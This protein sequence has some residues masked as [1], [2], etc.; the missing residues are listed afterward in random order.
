ML[1]AAMAGDEAEQMGSRLFTGDHL[2]PTILA[3]Q[4]LMLEQKIRDLLQRVSKQSNQIL[5]AAQVIPD[6]P[7]AVLDAA[8]EAETGIAKG[9][10]TPNLL[11][12]LVAMPPELAIEFEDGDEMEA[13]DLEAEEDSPLGNFRL[14][15]NNR[16]DPDDGNDNTVDDENDED[17]DVDDIDGNADED[18][19]EGMMTHL[20]AINLRLS[21][22]EF[23]DVQASLW[24]S[25]LRTA[26]GRLRK[27]GKQY[28][29][30]QRELAIAEAE[31]AWRAVWYDDSR[32]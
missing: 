4:H 20:A 2:T 16:Q 27:L 13:E 7:E 21:D 5:K 25:K 19:R 26:M 3:K 24:R 14:G 8:S 23:A 1:M 17:D 30:A 31:Q 22:I 32:Q 18:P 28:H 9:R 29:Q 6:L 11:N 10:S 15:R 12:V